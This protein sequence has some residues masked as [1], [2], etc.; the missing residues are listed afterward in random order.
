MPGKVCYLNVALSIFTF[1]LPLSISLS[2]LRLVFLLR[3]A[4]YQAFCHARLQR[5]HG[6]GEKL[7]INNDFPLTID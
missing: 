5:Q 4:L 1:L 2:L 3:S 6:V 7:F